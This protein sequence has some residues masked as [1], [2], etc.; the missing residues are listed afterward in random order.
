MGVGAAVTGNRHSARAG[1]RTLSAGVV[2]P[3]PVETPARAD[4]VA[5]GVFAPSR[6]STAMN[7]ST[8]MCTSSPTATGCEPPSP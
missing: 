4:E 3:A 1:L 6:W 7:A 8:D 2:V 5:T